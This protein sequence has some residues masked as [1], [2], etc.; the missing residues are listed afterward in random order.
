[1]N[2]GTALSLLRATRLRLGSFGIMPRAQPEDLLLESEQRAEAARQARV[3]AGLE[4]G[5]DADL[6]PVREGWL[7][8]VEPPSLDPVVFGPHY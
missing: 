7:S 2:A 4:Q 8:R 1:V 6:P 5:H 3:A